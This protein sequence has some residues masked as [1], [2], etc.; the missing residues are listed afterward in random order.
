MYLWCPCHFSFLSFY[1]INILIFSTTKKYI[2]TIF[3]WSITLSAHIGLAFC[4]VFV[5]D[6]NEKVIFHMSDGVK[7]YYE[8][9][10]FNGITLY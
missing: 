7:K 2:D 1:Q 10:V 8:F 6:P 9:F 5:V 4:F 3:F